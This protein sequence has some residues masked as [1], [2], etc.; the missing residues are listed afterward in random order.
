MFSLKIPGK[1]IDT[2][3]ELLESKLTLITFGGFMV[4]QNVQDKGI[5][6]QINKKIIEEKTIVSMQQLYQNKEYI[7]DTS[8]GKSSILCANIPI[9]MIMIQ[10][11]KQINGSKF[12]F[13]KEKYR[14]A[15]LLTI[16]MSLRLSKQFRDL[17]NL[18]LVCWV[19][20]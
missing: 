8:L 1:Q 7:I 18:R 17:V 14:N 3:K 20:I 10:N 19:I 15:M 5:V 13:I 6:A 12:R 16:A 11:L 2:L 9:K 4:L